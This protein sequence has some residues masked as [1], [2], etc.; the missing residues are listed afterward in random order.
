MN[1]VRVLLRKA[2]ADRSTMRSNAKQSLPFR[3]LGYY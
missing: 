2:G 3:S 1:S